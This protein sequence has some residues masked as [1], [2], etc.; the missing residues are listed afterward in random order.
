MEQSKDNIYQQQP[1][2]PSSE[3]NTSQTESRVPPSFVRERNGIAWFAGGLSAAA[4][5][6][7]SLLR[8]PKDAIVKYV[9]GHKDEFATQ[10]SKLEEIAKEPVTGGDNY[11]K[12]KTRWRNFQS[13]LDNKKAE[14]AWQRHLKFEAYSSKDKGFLD[15]PFNEGKA[16]ALLFSAVIA[17]GVGAIIYSG[18]RMLTGGRDELVEDVSYRNREKAQR[19]LA[20]NVGVQGIMRG[21]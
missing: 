13:A 12:L 6:L 21:R 19:E 20:E 7:F 2:A 11:A 4:A 16:S 17:V 5:G 10:I 8:F 3:L 14:K 15:L 18:V 1:Q 9:E